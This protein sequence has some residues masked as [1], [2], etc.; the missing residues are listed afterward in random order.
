MSAPCPFCGAENW[1]EGGVILDCAWACGSYRMPEGIFCRRNA[2]Y[3]RELAAL[4][5]RLK[6]A[7]GDNDLSACSKTI[8]QAVNDGELTDKHFRELIRYI[9]TEIRK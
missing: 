2:C 4:R 1:T 8:T 3:E 5:A 9:L 6:T 7:E